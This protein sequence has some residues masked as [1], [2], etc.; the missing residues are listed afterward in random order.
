MRDYY[1]LVVRQGTETSLEKG[2]GEEEKAAGVQAW[3]RAGRCSV[4]LREKAVATAGDAPLHGMVASQGEGEKVAAPV[5]I[6]IG[7]GGN[8][9]SV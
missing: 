6:Q 1:W 8:N 2:A 5:E 9:E 3:G 4:G 7:R